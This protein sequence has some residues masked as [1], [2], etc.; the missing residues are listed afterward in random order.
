MRGTR[1]GRQVCHIFISQITNRCDVE[2][3]ILTAS[4]PLLIQPS[5]LP[6]EVASDGIMIP[7]HLTKKFKSPL[8]LR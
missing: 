5:L 4:R 8:D 6:P 2:A 1:R 3:R 7:C